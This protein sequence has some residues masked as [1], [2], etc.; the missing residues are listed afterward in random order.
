MPLSAFTD[1]A[2]AGL[3]EG[4][5]EVAVGGAKGWYDRFEPRRQEVMRELNGL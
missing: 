2:Y 5:E 1:E 3:V 4:K